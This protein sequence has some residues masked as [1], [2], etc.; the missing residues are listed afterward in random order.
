MT[1]IK[2][3]TYGEKLIV[4]EKVTLSSGN[5]N[6]AELHVMLDEAWAAYPNISATFETKKYTEPVERLM[7]PKTSRE[8]ACVIP[9][10]VLREQG[11]LEIGIIGISND[12]EM[13]KTSSIAKYN[14]VRG[15][16]HSAVTLEPSMDLY[17]QYLA[18]MD[19]SV[20]PLFQAYRRD[21]DGLYTAM[22]EDIQTQHSNF[23]QAMIELTQPNILW[24]NSSKTKQ[25]T[26]SIPN[27]K[28]YNHFL[29]IFLEN[30]NTSVPAPQKLVSQV[31]EKDTTYRFEYM[32]LEGAHHMHYWDYSLSDSG[33][34]L[35]EESPNLVVNYVPYQIIGWV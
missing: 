9:P 23:Q 18:S 7:L 34:T 32:D 21:I 20:A 2:L 5:V 31:S 35:G 26:Y 8:Y 16:S 1:E 10:E 19:A 25:T 14:I 24:T 12:S 6:S 28:N 29:V 3:H 30:Y 4:S 22:I 17:Q 15:A 33:L 11:I 13:V 27:L